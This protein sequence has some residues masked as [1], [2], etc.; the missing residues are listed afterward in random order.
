MH[1]FRKPRTQ[2]SLFHYIKEESE[3]SIWRSADWDFLF[4]PIREAKDAWKRPRTKPSLFHY[5]EEEPK[6][7][8]SWKEFF[9]DLFT[10]FKNPLF[11]SS[12]FSDP[13]ALLEEQSQGRTRRLEARSVSVLVHVCI[14][15]LGLWLATHSAVPDEQL[16]KVVFI[17]NRTPV[18]I[19]DEG[20]GREGGGGGGGGR[21]E[22]LQPRAGRMPEPVSAE[23]IAPD[24]DNPRPL[25]PADDLLANVLV[26]LPVSIPLDTALPIGD[27]TAPANTSPSFGSGSG[28]GI[29]TGQG[30]GVGSG[31]GSGAGSGSGGGFGSG[32]GGGIGDGV[33]PYYSGVDFKEPELLKQVTPQYT[34]EGRLARAEGIVILE[35]MIRKNGT[36]DNFKVVKSLGFG[37]DEAAIHTVAT[38][39]RFKPATYKGKNVDYPAQIEVRFQ[40]F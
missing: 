35:F 14:L 12:V 11:I 27:V 15:G 26:E 7:P 4:H 21:Q 34:E 38:K 13:E 17:E 33:G 16:E 23:I 8:F 39:W 20:D 18:F 24:P 19:P 28:G 3:E 40:I 31:Q 25:M 9:R 1:S 6:E 10:G 29:G 37:L 5:V 22:Q 30:R 32:S 2:A 36:L